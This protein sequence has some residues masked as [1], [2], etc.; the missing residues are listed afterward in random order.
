MVLKRSWIT[1]KAVILAHKDGMRTLTT[2]RQTLYYLLLLGFALTITGAMLGWW[3]IYVAP[4]L[5]TL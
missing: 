2:T 4:L 3:L 5:G 1:G